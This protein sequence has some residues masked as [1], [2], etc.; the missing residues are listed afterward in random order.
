MSCIHVL[1]WELPFCLTGRI[2]PSPIIS[3]A[4]NVSSRLFFT[5][6][7]NVVHVIAYTASFVHCL[8]SFNWNLHKLQEV[9]S[10]SIVISLIASFAVLLSLSSL[11]LAKTQYHAPRPHYIHS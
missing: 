4:W 9:F 1:S 2:L 8:L 11:S 10:V 7:T 6:L 3:C 5:T